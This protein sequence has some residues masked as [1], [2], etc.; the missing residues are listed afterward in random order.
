MLNDW[1]VKN[2]DP[3]SA[4]RIKLL[5]EAIHLVPSE[6]LHEV[7]ALV[8]GMFPKPSESVLCD[9]NVGTIAREVLACHALQSAIASE[10][11]EPQFMDRC[12]I[13]GAVKVKKVF[14]NN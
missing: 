3:A 7:E 14:E 10:A 6:R 5:S 8:F 4:R 13:Y 12:R 11:K 2:C 1:Y 9:R